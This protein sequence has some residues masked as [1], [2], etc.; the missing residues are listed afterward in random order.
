MPVILKGTLPRPSRLALTDK[1]LMR[2]V[3]QM[4]VR[5]IQSRTRQGRDSS[6]QAFQP[7]APAYAKRKAEAGVSSGAVDLTVSGDMLNA[8]QI[9]EVTDTTVTLGWLR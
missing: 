3:G 8:L 4:A 1:A 5:A 7:Y 2:E 6:G 9:V